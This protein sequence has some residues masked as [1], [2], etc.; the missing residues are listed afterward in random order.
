MPAL[1]TGGVTAMA[2]AVA[3][4]PG[5]HAVFAIVITA[6][7]ATCRSAGIR[8]ERM[9]CLAGDGIDGEVRGAVAVAADGAGGHNGP[10][11]LAAPDRRR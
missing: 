11:A 1:Q 10:A 5:E 9:G 2:A 8:R 7:V 3:V 4:P 6:V